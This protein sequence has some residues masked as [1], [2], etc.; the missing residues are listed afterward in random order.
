[1][2]GTNTSQFTGDTNQPVERVNWVLATNYCGLLTQ[3]EQTAGRIPADWAYRLPTEAEWEYG[4]RAGAR[5][6][7]FGYGDDLSYASLGNYAWYSA[8]SGSTTHPVEQK[9][10]NP[11]GL[12]D[13]HGNVWEW[14]QDWYGTYPGGSVTDPQGPASGDGRVFRGGAW[15]TDPAWSR[16]GARSYDNPNNA[17]NI[18]G[19]RVVLAPVVP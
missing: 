3:T 8:N 5:T 11:W 15:N 18:L 16:A 14:C 13:M 1:V 10:A 17:G 6:T 4:C 19:F 9:L 7:R 12:M 2:M